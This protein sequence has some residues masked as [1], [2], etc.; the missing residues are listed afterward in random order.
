ME[1]DLDFF[2]FGHP[3]T[4]SGTRVASQPIFRSTPKIIFLE[5]IRVDFDVVLALDPVVVVSPGVGRVLELQEH[6]VRA[7]SRPALHP[8][9]RPERPRE[10]LL[11]LPAERLEVL[12][13]H[14]HAIFGVRPSRVAARA[15]GGTGKLRAAAPS[16]RESASLAAR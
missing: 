3:E 14:V 7:I 4:I 16:L 12:F 6:A 2:V 9:P 5:F 10:L 8:P 11:A 15:H 1:I 13:G